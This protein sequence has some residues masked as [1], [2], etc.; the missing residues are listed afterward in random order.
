MIPS[1]VDE[2]SGVWLLGGFFLPHSKALPNQWFWKINFLFW[3][4]GLVAACPAGCGIANWYDSHLEHILTGTQTEGT[5]M[6][7]PIFFRS[8]D[9]CRF[10]NYHHF[11]G[12]NVH[13]RSISMEFLAA[14]LP[15]ASWTARR[16]RTKCVWSRY[17]S[18]AEVRQWSWQSLVATRLP[19][20]KPKCFLVPLINMW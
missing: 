20:S 15:R 2:L 10:G 19:K 5:L 4:N 18:E 1:L 7:I 3:A 17:K 12:P 16:T 13:P 11:N 8:E 9:G 14:V 6:L